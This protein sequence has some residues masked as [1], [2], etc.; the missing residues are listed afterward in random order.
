MKTLSPKN[1]M[2]KIFGKYSIVL[3]IG[4]MQLFML[5][6]ALWELSLMVSPVKLLLHGKY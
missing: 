4:K 2:G 5:C 1:N 3:A 6:A